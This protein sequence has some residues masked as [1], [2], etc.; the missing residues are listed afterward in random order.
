MELKPIGS[1]ILGANLILNPQTLYSLL[2][3]LLS[4]QSLC[5]HH[6]VRRTENLILLDLEFCC[7]CCAVLSFLGGGNAA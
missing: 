3:V 5:F 6:T 1:Y 2:S 7:F 4:W